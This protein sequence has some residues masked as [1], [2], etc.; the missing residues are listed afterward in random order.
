MPDLRVIYELTRLAYTGED[1]G[2]D[3]TFHVR[4]GAGLVSF[5]ARVGPAGDDRGRD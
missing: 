3:W 4:T 2:E 1:V 5:E